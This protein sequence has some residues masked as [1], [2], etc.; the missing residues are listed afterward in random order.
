MLSSVGGPS[1]REVV[2]VYAVVWSA[3]ETDQTP[4]RVQLK[5]RSQACRGCMRPPREASQLQIP[6]IRKAGVRRTTF[7]QPKLTARFRYPK[8]PRSIQES[9]QVT[10]VRHRRPDCLTRY[11]RVGRV[12]CP[13]LVSAGCSAY[14]FSLWTPRFPAETQSSGCCDSPS[15]VEVSHSHGG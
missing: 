10:I 4:W 9:L 15:P 12:A 14:G 13:R 6:R 3:P 1:S 8:R 5:V 7:L 11:R 2:S